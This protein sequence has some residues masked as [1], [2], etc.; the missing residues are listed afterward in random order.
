MLALRRS[1]SQVGPGYYLLQVLT[2]DTGLHRKCRSP[3]GTSEV[4]LLCSARVQCCRD[5]EQSPDDRSISLGRGRDEN[6]HTRD[7]G[8]LK[9]S[10]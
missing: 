5:T 1:A 8:E 3:A 2:I 7:N 9:D 6:S 4:P 10:L